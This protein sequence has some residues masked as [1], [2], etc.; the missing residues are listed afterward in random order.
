M[1]ESIIWKVIPSYNPSC[2]KRILARI[3]YFNSN[4]YMLQVMDD[5][6]QQQETTFIRPHIIKLPVHM[7]GFGINAEQ[8]YLNDKIHNAG[9]P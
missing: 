8:T 6:P 4:V 7:P 3:L 9:N 1:L 2:E 5:I